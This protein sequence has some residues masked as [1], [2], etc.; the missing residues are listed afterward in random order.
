MIQFAVSDLDRPLNNLQIFL[1]YLELV[2]T[3]L[4]NDWDPDTLF[5]GHWC[6]RNGWKYKIS[7][8]FSIRFGL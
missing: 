4:K 3:N 1:F 8:D 2:A 6:A 5:D 7:S